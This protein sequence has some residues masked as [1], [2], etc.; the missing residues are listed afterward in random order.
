M[1]WAL[2]G[3]AC[4]WYPISKVWR[5]RQAASTLDFIGLVGVLATYPLCMAIFH[6]TPFDLGLVYGLIS[7]M[8]VIFFFSMKHYLGVSLPFERRLRIGLYSFAGAL[9]MLGVTNVWHGQFALFQ[10]HSPGVPNHLLYEAEMRWGLL[11]VHLTT[12]ILVLGTLITAVAQFSRARFNLTH[13]AIGVGVPAVG[14]WSAIV[15]EHPQQLFGVPVNGFL[16]CSTI[17]L[18]AINCTI[19]RR[20]FLEFRVITRATILSIMPEAMLVLSRNRYIVD[21]NL[22]FTALVGEAERACVDRELAEVL[23]ELD[24]ALPG[25]DSEFEFEI[26]R[27]DGRRVFH[28]HAQSVNRVSVDDTQVLLLLRDITAQRIALEA[29][30]ESQRELRAANA[31]LERL[32]MTDTLTGLKNRRYFQDRLQA[33]FQRAQRSD[34]PVA[35]ISIDIDHFKSINDLLGHGVGDL[36]LCHV[37]RVLE[38]E[39]R[40][41]D[42]IAR[43]GGEEFMV[44]LLDAAAEQVNA[45]AQRLCRALRETPY[46]LDSGRELRITASFGFS[47]LGVG[48]T[49]DS[50]LQRA[51]EALY[52]AKNAGRDQ[53]VAA[54]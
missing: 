36:S 41:V 6:L 19:V 35:L 40:N 29:L 11:A 18:L 25:N 23:P 13:Y 14:V 10:P 20:R 24:S 52:A 2:L 30:E 7:F 32:S 15:A 3:L 48:D 8:P 16:V 53:V 39:C 34:V 38:N 42:T 22:A 1:V 21:A 27:A 9:G 47:L 31:A 44:L 45:T 28:V 4:G 26:S 50:A 46:V 54:C 49:V 5:Y 33:E 12:G 17:A 51:D 43:V 37:A